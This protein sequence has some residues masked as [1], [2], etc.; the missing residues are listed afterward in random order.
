M[1][2]TPLEPSLPMAPNVMANPMAGMQAPYQAAKPV[3][4]IDPLKALMRMKL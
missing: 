2:V 3:P 4:L 1:N